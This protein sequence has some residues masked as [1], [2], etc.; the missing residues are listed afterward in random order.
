MRVIVQIPC[1]NETAT[2]PAAV[3]AVPR[4][5]AGVDSVEILVIDDGSTDGA[6]RAAREA[7]NGL[8]RTLV[9]SG[10]EVML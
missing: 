10:R 6:A 2:L 1:L 9:V 5:I 4:Q 7:L 8:T 3:A